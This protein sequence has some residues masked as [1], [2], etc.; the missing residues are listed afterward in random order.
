VVEIEVSG[1]ETRAGGKQSM[2]VV[3]QLYVI[4]KVLIMKRHQAGFTMIELI[5]VIV[6][7]GVLAATALPKFIDVQSNA[8]DSS[9]KGVAGSFASAMSVNYGGC[10]VN[11]HD[12]LAGKCVLVNSCGD[13]KD[14][15]QGG[16][17]PD[18]YTV[19]D[20]AISTTN[21]TT[22]TC[23]VVQTDGGLDLDFDGIAAG[24]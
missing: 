23:T 2:P 21:G 15:L 16:E 20:T 5:V 8:K 3:Y 4:E 9:L 6:I 10:L 18:G 22:G 7:L 17:L 11:S 19:A 14:L 12:P 24:N 13:V 1:L